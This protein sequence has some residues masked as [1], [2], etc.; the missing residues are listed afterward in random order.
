MFASALW[1][2]DYMFALANVNIT[3]VNFHGGVGAPYTPISYKGDTPDVRPLYY[4][5][6]AFSEA[7]AN[8][9]IVVNTTVTSTNEL[10]KAWA[11]RDE[12]NYE[13]VV[14]VHKDLNSTQDCSVCV[15]SSQALHGPAALVRLHV[16]AGDAHSKYGVHWAGQTFDDTQDGLPSGPRVEETVVPDSNCWTFQLPP[17]TAAMLSLPLA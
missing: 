6:L 1:G 14:V 3:R 15:Q 7:T 8:N 12:A 11:V 13:R 4:A 9:S 16:H 5:M 2:L 17:G 10:I